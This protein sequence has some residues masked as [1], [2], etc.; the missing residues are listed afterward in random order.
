ME[1][2][3]TIQYKKGNEMPADFLSRNMVESIKILD[4][5]L[6]N[7]QDKDTFCK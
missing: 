1:L 7:L 6:D 5:D 2:D 4:K 3:F